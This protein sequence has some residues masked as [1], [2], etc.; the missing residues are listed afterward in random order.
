MEKQYQVIISSDEYELLKSNTKKLSAIIEKSDKM[1]VCYPIGKFEPNEFFQVIHES[2]IITLLDNQIKVLN[3]YLDGHKETI[4]NLSD[5]NAQLEIK[6][7]LLLK[8]HRNVINKKT[9]LQKIFLWK[10]SQTKSEN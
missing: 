1:V 8:K 3:N 2:E 5:E 9:F 10:K 7:N 4:K 6:N